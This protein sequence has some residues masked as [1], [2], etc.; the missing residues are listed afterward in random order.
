VSAAHEAAGTV[1]AARDAVEV[2]AGGWPFEF[3]NANYPDVDD[4]AVVIQALMPDYVASE[5][6]R[7]RGLAWLLGMQNEDGGWAAFDRG[8]DTQA[9]R[10]LPF[11]DF[12]EVLDP[13]SA[14]VTAH[15]LELLARLGYGR[16]HPAVRRGLDYL[17]HEQENDGSWFGRWGVNYIYGTAAVLLALRELGYDGGDERLARASAWLSGCRNPDGGWGECCHSYSDASR[18]GRGTSSA[19]QTAWAVLGLLAAGDRETARSGVAWLVEHQRSDGCW[20]EPYFTGTGF[21]GDFYIKYHE[22]RNYFPL[23]ALGRWQRAM[24]AE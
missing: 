12:G 1:S 7:Q 24:P 8:N 13:S 17:W 16:E 5:P 14:D 3:A 10:A 21:P 4:T 19:S 18:R 15:S 20:D 2:E 9:V 22:Y 6:A 23:L 11:C